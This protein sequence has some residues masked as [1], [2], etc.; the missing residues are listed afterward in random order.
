MKQSL[1]FILLCVIGM[2]N[3]LTHSQQPTTESLDGN[4]FADK[5]VNALFDRR[6]QKDL[7]LVDDQKQ[8]LKS[9]MDEIQA[10]RKTMAT[11]LKEFAQS[12]SEGE[13]EEKR[14]ELVAS[15][16]A[17]KNKYYQSVTKVLL[18]HQ[19]ERLGQLTAQL[20]IRDAQNKY[21]VSVL[22]PEMKKFLD[23]D[24]KQAEAIKKK[25]IE[26]RERLAKQVKELTD[27]AKAELM[28]QLTAEQRKKYQKLIGDPLG[29]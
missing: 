4:P 25:A 28:D 2:A 17:F 15:F 9:L 10:K 11:T 26:V 21:P 14:N 13:I 1:F 27:K 7:E 16:E 23:I 19:Q 8:Q 5:M 3:G 20:M 12:A 6:V 18:P 29:K 24:E 22:A